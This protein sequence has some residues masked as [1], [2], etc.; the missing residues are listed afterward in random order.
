MKIL[1]AGGTGFVGGSLTRNLIKSGHQ[2]SLLV[3]EKSGHKIKKFDKISAVRCEYDYPV[4][5]LD[6]EFDVLVNCAGIIREFPSKGITFDKAHYEIVKYLVDL[7]RANSINR[8]IQI[9]ALGVTPDARTGYF[10]TKYRG[11]EA[12]RNSGLNFTIFRPSTIFGPDD[13]FIN[14]LIRM[15]K[16]LPLVPVIGNGEYRMQP[17]YIDDLCNVIIRSLNENFTFG[18]TFDIGGPEIITYNRMLE[19]LETV[20][21]RR[22]PKIHQ[23]VFIMRILAKVLG[24]F[25]WFPITSEQLTMLLDESFTDDN[26]LF[27]RYN[28]HPRPFEEGL[29]DYL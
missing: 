26:S 1:I 7:A 28:I 15:I 19:A 18:N 12:I 24:R 17:V 21:G 5:S 6:S 16:K 22:S 23:P 3:R 27:E 20:L 11:E 10:K 8:F 29:R 9:S 4:V 14:M 2:V 25:S 13:D